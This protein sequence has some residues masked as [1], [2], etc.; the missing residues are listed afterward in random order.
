MSQ[1]QLKRF[2][3]S[4]LFI[5]RNVRRLCFAEHTTKNQNLS[6]I[7]KKFKCLISV[8]SI[9]LT[10]YYSCLCLLLSKR[11]YI[12]L[13]RAWV[14][15]RCLHA[16]AWISQSQC[17]DLDQ[18]FEVDIDYLLNQEVE[19]SWIKLSIYFW[20]GRNYKRMSVY[21]IQRKQAK[22]FQN[23]ARFW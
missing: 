14:I 3:F 5:E 13:W 2:K 6:L 1:Y 15:L 21:Y 11:D 19:K 12:M 8:S 23:W 16:K 22:S 4:Y 9:V 20:N 17:W 10:Q 7:H 18:N